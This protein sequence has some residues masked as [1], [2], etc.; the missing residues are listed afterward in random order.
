MAQLDVRLEVSVMAESQPTVFL[1]YRRNASA[2]IARAI[3]MDLRQHGYDVFMDVES[4]ES[5]QVSPIILNQIAARAHF[6][7]IL[8]PGTLDRCQAPDDWVRREIEHAIELGRNVVPILVNDFIFDDTTLV[9]LPE[10]LRAL[11]SY[12]GVTMRHDYFDAAMERLRTHFLKEPAQGVITPAPPQD[13]PVVQQKIEEA[14]R[15]ATP[16]IPEHS[17]APARVVTHTLAPHITNSIGMEFVLIVAGTFLMGSKPGSPYN[18]EYPVHHVTI[19]QPFYLG[20]YAV[21]QGQWKAVMGTNP[22][23]FIGGRDLIQEIGLDRSLVPVDRNRPVEQV[24]WEDVQDFIQRLNAKEGGTN[25]RLPTEAEWEYACRAGSTTEYSFGDD[26]NQLGAYGWYDGNSNGETHPVGQRT[27]NAWGLYDMH[28]NVYEWVQDWIGE[29]APE[30][31]TDPQGPASGWSRVFR[32]GSWRDNASDCRS[33][34]RDRENTRY[35]QGRLGF[36]LLR[37][38]Q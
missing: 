36:R 38:A 29:Y 28:G 32:G 23:R 5:G 31:A 7:V 14:A 33:A 17:A 6:L 15:E 16:T 30:P 19:S 20:K 25:Y 13:A 12:A 34:Y 9:R 22:S 35:S 2:F 1:S 24:S 8:T 18:K 4:T 37:M 26:P 11:P 21:T 3:F 10:T 27:P